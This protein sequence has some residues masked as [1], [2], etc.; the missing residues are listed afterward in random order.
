MERLQRFK[1]CEKIIALDARVDDPRV[2]G[3]RYKRIIHVGDAE[4]PNAATSR[5]VKELQI[6][7]VPADERA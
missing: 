1:H 6:G 3:Q 5:E 7:R 2:P 4:E